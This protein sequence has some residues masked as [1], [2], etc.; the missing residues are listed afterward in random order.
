MTEEEMKAKLA[1]L[2][3]AVEK[4]TK[5][6]KT[7]LDEKVKAKQEAEAAREAAEAAEE[8]KARAAKDVEALEKQITKRF[9]KQLSDLTKANQSYEGQLSQL[10]IDNTIQANLAKHN[11][12]P[13]YQKALTAMLKAEAKLEDGAAVVNGVSLEDH[14]ASF[15]GSDEGKVFVAAPANSGAAAMGSKTATVATPSTWNLTH[16]V[17]MKSD[18]P[19]EAAA[20]AAKHNKSFD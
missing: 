8:D 13:A 20:Y 17:T 3:A 1:E 19:A 6:K 5:E 4:A 12:S 11:V 15:V 7:L 18:N 2:E 10:L 9:E 14:I 16:Y